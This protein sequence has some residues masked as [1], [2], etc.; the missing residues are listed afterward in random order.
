MALNEDALKSKK[1]NVFIA[2]FALLA[3]VG[4]GLWV[5]QLN[6]GLFQTNMRNLESWGLYITNFMFFIGLSAGGL[7]ISSVP[8]VFG[9][10]GFGGIS[11]VA[12][13]T[14]ICCTVVAGVFIVFD[15]GQPLRVWELLVY[16]NFTSPLMWDVTVISAY[17]IISIVYL[18]ATVRHERGKGSDVAMRALSTVALILAVLVHS[19][20][21]WI[22]ALQNA[23]EMWHT[24][25]MAPWFVCSALVS[26]LAL[27]LVVVIALRKIGYL[28]VEGRYLVKMAKLLAVLVCVD[29]Y[30]FGCDLLTEAFPGGHGGEVAHMIMFGPLA[31][32]FWTEVAGCVIAAVIGFVPSLRKPSLFVVAGI[33]AMVAIFC[34]RCQIILGG[35]TPKNIDLVTAA[36]TYPLSDVG[37][38]VKATFS[39]LVYF[40]TPLEFGV[41][42]GVI[43][44]GVTLLV[45][46]L[47]YLP[48]KPSA[49][50]H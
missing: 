48:L 30:L 35:F 49:N 32:F 6:A 44:L 45:V 5:Y 47:K 7:I 50:S 27:V 21:A 46:G 29:L 11:K 24:A 12:V 26:G 15:L 42:L 22:F 31:P 19:V 9:I 2:V 18:W 3:V 23:R 41:T 25:I 39:S 28:E 37:A 43:S 16:S 4:I 33:A 13:W 38:Q 40:P 8:R 1:A 10:E 17:L 20:T 36:P 14:A 34:K